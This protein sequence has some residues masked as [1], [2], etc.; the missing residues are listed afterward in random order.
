LAALPEHVMTKARETA[1]KL[2]ELEAK[3]EFAFD[4]I[5]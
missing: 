1:N 2:T 5:D 4:R 3:G